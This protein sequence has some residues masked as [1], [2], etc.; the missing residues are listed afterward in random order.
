MGFVIYSILYYNIHFLINYRLNELKLRT[1]N[2]F[3]GRE[4]ELE[5][6]LKIIKK[7]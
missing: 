3:A 6:I 5:L 4:N 2:I 1:F 7:V